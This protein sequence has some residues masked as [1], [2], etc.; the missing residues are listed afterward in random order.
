MSDARQT[1]LKQAVRLLH[2]DPALA[3]DDVVR[4]ARVLRVRRRVHSIPPNCAIAV[5]VAP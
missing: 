3:E 2:G 1:Y 4:V 5:S